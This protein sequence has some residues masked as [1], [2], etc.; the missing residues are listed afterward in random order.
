MQ[1][2]IYKTYRNFIKEKFGE[3]VLK[4]TLN[5]G[6]SCPNRDGAISAGGCAFC[7][8][9][10]FS[11]AHDNVEPVMDQ[12]IK[13]IERNSKRFNKFIAYFQ[14]FTNTY[15]T[16]EHLKTLYEPVINTEKVIGLAVGTRPDCLDDKICE[17]LE[18]VSKRT[19]L[20]VEVG[21]Q[22][23]SDR[24]LKAINRGHTFK[25][26]EDAVYK[27]T[28]RNIEVVAHIMLGLPEEC[29]ADLDFT[30]RKIAELPISGVKIHQL[31]VV[32]DT[33]V[34]TLYQDNKLNVLSLEEYAQKAAKFIAMLRPNQYLHRIVAD[35]TVKNGL[36]APLWSEDKIGSVNYIRSYME[37]NKLYQ[38]LLYDK[39]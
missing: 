37:K 20:S 13:Q 12:L 2:P 17:Y 34:E 29:D 16:V 14:P 32:E 4:V 18:D 15:G 5:G 26:F 23:A 27:L 10:A 3:P 30:A 6:F 11:R 31:M 7:E 35:S 9:R 1:R 24:V 21:L 28:D 8:N 38:G 19:Y 22:S 33:A 25:Q 36:I 39:D